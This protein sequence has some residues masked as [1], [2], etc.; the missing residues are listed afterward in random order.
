MNDI[1]DLER[2]FADLGL[3]GAVMQGVEAAGFKNP[4]SIQ[5]A[6]IPA[7]LSGQDVLGQAKT[8]TGKTAAFGLPILQQADPQGGAQ[9]LILAPTRELAVQITHEINDL[10][11]FTAIKAVPIIGGE[12]FQQQIGALRAGAQ[13]MVGTPGRV[14]DMKQ[15]GNISFDLVRWAVLDEVDRMLD[16]G[17]RD[18]I[19]KILGKITRPHQTMFVSATI[20][21]EIDRLARQFMRSNVL[22]I[23]TVADSLT[24]SLVVQRYVPVKPWDKDRM[25]MHLL[26][27][28]QA[29]LTVVFCRLKRKVTKV[30]AM[31]KANG[32]DAFEIHGDLPQSK[33]NRIMERLR[34]GKLEVLVASDLASRGLDVE[35]ITH[36][37]NYDL[38]EDPE[39]YVHR[40]GRTARAGRGGTAWSFVTPDQGQ[41]LTEIEKLTGVNIERLEYGDFAEGTRPGDWYDDKP[42]DIPR[43]AATTTPPRNRYAESASMPA[44]E[45]EEA[46]KIDPNLFPGGVVP[47]GPPPKTLGSRFRS[48][49]R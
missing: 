19:R 7:A 9:A 3:S 36:V 33:R 37:I 6:L 16:I 38:P 30:A 2:S 18:D 42:G 34:T 10:G 23:S 45:P 20:S 41:L 12:S 29:A 26:G 47:K 48:R 32:I 39:V 46:A 21:P 14:M 1:F 43:M 8:G 35:G 24:V 49:R 5:A 25:L 27:H 11:K 13:I 22:K 4:T 31:L 28:E 17:F 15:R 44:N 40:I